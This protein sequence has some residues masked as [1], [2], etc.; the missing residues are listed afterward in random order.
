M[1]SWWKGETVFRENGHNMNI[2]LL[3]PSTPAFASWSSWHQRMF[4]KFKSKYRLLH[5]NSR[6]RKHYSYR[7]VCKRPGPSQRR[8]PG[9]CWTLYLDQSQRSPAAM[10]KTLTRMM[11]IVRNGVLL[12]FGEN[13]IARDS[14]PLQWWKNNETRFPTLTVLDI[15]VCA[16]NF[17][18]LRMSILCRQKCCHKGRSKPADHVDMLTF[19]YDKS[20]YITHTN[21]EREWREGRGVV[22]WE[23]GG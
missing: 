18:S 23:C 8:P 13:C 5:W 20:D 12:Y 4:W 14:S 6:D 10:R 9:L 1:V 15:L 17:N 11:V 3:L 16:C 7:Q 21:K 2:T 19:L 22:H